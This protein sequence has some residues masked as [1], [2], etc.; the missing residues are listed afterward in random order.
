MDDFVCTR[1]GSCCRWRGAVKVTGDE[2]DAIAAYLN[3]PPEEFLE[4]HTVITPDRQHLSLCEKPGGECEFLTVGGDELAACAIQSVK[5]RQCREFP[6]KWNF[7]GWEKQ[8]PGGG[9]AS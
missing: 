1:C 2:V 5:P 3:M 4:R 7:R 9:K 6:V 8:C